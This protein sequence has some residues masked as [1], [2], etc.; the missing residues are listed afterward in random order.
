MLRVASYAC[1]VAALAAGVMFWITAARRGCQSDLDAI[2]QAV[3]G[4]FIFHLFA[5]GGL[6]LA[7]LHAFR[8][9]R[10]WWPVAANAAAIGAFWLVAW[11]WRC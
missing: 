2:T 6:L 4:L 8:A 1:F 5:G 11:S 3:A 9:V 7:L 10:D